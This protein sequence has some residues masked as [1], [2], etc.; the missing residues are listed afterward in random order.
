MG[1]K[2]PFVFEI[3]FLGTSASAPSVRRGLSALI[4]K[5]NEYRFL[6]D[7]GEGTQRQILQS[8]IGFKQ[9]NRILL[10]HSHLDHILG[11]GGLMSTFMRW[12]SIESLEIFGGK[13]ALQRVRILLDEVVLVGK[14]PPMPFSYREITPGVIIDESDFTVSA[15]P[16]SHRGPDCLGYCFEQKARRPF[17]AEKADQLGVPFGPQRRDLVNGQS[18]TLE[19]GRVVTSEDVLGPLQ[20]GTKLV[21]IGDTG[22]TDNLLDYVRDADGLVIEGTYLHEDAEIAQQFGHLTARSAAELAKN[23]GVKQLF[24]THISRRYREKDVI[25][26]VQ[27]VLPGAVVARDFDNFIIKRE[28]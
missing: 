16:V 11:L 23:A 7:C 6:I 14:K 19:D 15:F 20:T 28:S 9:L 3:L 22:R 5:H 26:E 13:N 24:L 18:I 27:S 25:A 17:L 2:G 10:T 1:I 12:E 21:V 8:G 4:V